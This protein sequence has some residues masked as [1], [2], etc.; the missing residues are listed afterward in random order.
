VAGNAVHIKI[1]AV[2]VELRDHRCKN[3]PTHS[4][5]DRD[6]VTPT[7]FRKPFPMRIHPSLPF[8][9]LLGT[10]FNAAAQSDAYPSR[11]I[12]FVVANAAGGGE[13]STARTIATKLSTGLGQQIVI[14]NRAGAAGTIAAE[15]T[16]KSPPDGYT[17]MMGS[18]GALAVNQSLNKSLS[19]NPQRDFAPVGMIVTQSNILVVNPVV[20]ARTVRELMALAKSRPGKLTFGSSGSGNAGHLAGELFKTMAKIDMVHV[21]YKGGAATML[22]LIGGRIDLVFSSA[23]PALPQI[24]AD[25]VRAL[26][27]TTMKRSA[28]LPEVPT[29]AES[30]LPGYEAVN[31]YG[32]VVPAKTPAVAV[33]RLN[34]E[35]VRALNAPEIKTALFK[36]GLDAAPGGSQEFGDFMR[37]EAVKWAKVVKDAGI[38]AD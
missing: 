20:P 3:P 16:V 9:L 4:T 18:V 10:A 2:L 21:P 38:T 22:D 28:Q 29:M 25:K 36:Q 32:L 27:V 35:L 23:A 8:A 26:A 13:D 31:W 5:H 34:A 12:R 14:D 33:Q 6:A 37:A 11:P 15:I 17:M 24:A 7:F 19:Y 1:A 30:G